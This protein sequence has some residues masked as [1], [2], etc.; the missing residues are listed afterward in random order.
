MRIKIALGVLVAI[1]VIMQVIPL[2]R[3]N[4]PVT[5][6]VPADAEA[7]M[8]LKRACYD[9]HSNASIWPWYSKVAPV[10]FLIARDVNK[11]RDHLNFSEWDN[12]DSFDILDISQEIEEEVSEA[13]MP[14]PPY[15][16]M[17][18][19]AK[20]T[21]DERSL[22]IDWA[23]RLPGMGAVEEADSTEMMN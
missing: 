11:G 17:H 3:D 23:R 18:P 12:Y 1:F 22:L 16:I 13:N 15:L 8:I 6:W 7:E 14:F 9:C 10:S 19:E 21:D 20:L 4:P 5:E 2:K